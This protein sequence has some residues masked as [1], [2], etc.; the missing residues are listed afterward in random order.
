MSV[1]SLRRAGLAASF[2][3]LG[4]CE[5][6]AGI[7]NLAASGDASTGGMTNEDASPGDGRA[8]SVDGAPVDATAQDVSPSDATG[9]DASSPDSSAADS[10]TTDAPTFVEA[11]SAQDSSA[12]VDAVSVQGTA[13]DGPDGGALTG[14]A[15]PLLG[16]LIDNVTSE[17]LAGW[18]LSQNGREGTWFTYA[19]AVDGGVVPSPQ[20]ATLNPGLVLNAVPTYDG[21][22]VPS[23][24]INILGNGLASYAGVGFNLDVP[25][26]IV[27]AYN[28]SAYEGI[29]FWGRVDGDAGST[30]VRVDFPDQNTSPTGGICQNAEAGGGCDDYF[31]MGVEFT[32]RWQEFVVYFA[33]TSQV[34]F[35]TRVP[36]GLDTHA[37]YSVQFQVTG[38]TPPAP[39]DIWIDNVYFIYKP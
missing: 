25:S 31:G 11:S 15:G 32:P 8:S 19:A 4:G 36:S 37:I 22:P 23:Q 26:N 39:F 38:T 34:G 21:P 27:T 17:P 30:S 28:A 6:I 9:T 2:L 18:I 29:A 35:G 13:I 33:Q 14:D 5:V 24:A 1:A 3:L 16:D 20:A 10:T 12:P 7:E